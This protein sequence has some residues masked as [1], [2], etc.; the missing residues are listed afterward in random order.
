M[1]SFLQTYFQE[2]ETTHIPWVQHLIMVLPHIRT[3]KQEGNAII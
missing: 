2:E 1:H 3:W